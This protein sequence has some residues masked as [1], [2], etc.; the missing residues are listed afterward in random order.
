MWRSSQRHSVS[1]VLRL[2]VQWWSAW[3]AAC[4]CV[5]GLAFVFNRQQRDS[6]SSCESGALYLHPDFQ[7]SERALLPPNG[8]A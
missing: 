7:S 8:G 6:E 4:V 1:S 2:S 5:C 3:K